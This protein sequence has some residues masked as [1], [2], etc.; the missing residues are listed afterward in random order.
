M[1][2]RLTAGSV[3]QIEHVFITDATAT[4]GSGLTALVFGGL[5][6]YYIRSGGTLTAMTPITITT[7]GT[8]DTDVTSDKI[9]FKL[10]SDANAPGLY[11]IHL[12][13]NILV[14]GADYVIIM[15]TAADAVPSLLR[16]EIEQEPL[17]KQTIA[18]GVVRQYDSDGTT[19]A[20]TLTPSVD[21]TSAP[22]LNIVTPT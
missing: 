22:T 2:R 11:E 20:E 18:T 16:V 4:D 19:V 21:S 5:T 1:S 9:G 15:L 13:D 14:R 17:R 3:K 6:A 7:L 8:W 12:P 10:I